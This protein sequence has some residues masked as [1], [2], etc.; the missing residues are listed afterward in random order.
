MKN[1]H[2]KYSLLLLILF[3]CDSDCIVPNTPFT[4]VNINF[5]IIGSGKI[6]QTDTNMDVLPGNYVITNQN[7]WTV[8]LSKINAANPE[9][10]QSFNTNVNFNDFIVVG[11]FDEVRSGGANSIFVTSI[12]ENQ[13]QI[14]ISVGL[15]TGG[16]MNVINQAFQLVKMPKPTKTI[17]FQ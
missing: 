2:L 14:N 16:I 12:I 1:L 3:S 5:N 17:T 15:Q 4:P 9:T 7:E 10:T 13:T 6:S 11:V 8:L